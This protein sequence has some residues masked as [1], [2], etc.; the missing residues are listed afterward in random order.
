MQESIVLVYNPRN[1]THFN[2]YPPAKIALP[3][4]DDVVGHEDQVYQ[5]NQLPCVQPAIIINEVA[6]HVRASLAK[7]IDELGGIGVFLMLFARVSFYK[8][9]LD[10][11]IFIKLS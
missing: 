5:L 9:L 3:E 11:G 1:T 6:P 4:T 10:R 7:C 2:F 8:S